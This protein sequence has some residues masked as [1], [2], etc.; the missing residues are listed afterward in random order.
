[1]GRKTK[2]EKGLL[3]KLLS[4]ALDGQVGDDLTTSGG[5]TVWTTIK[6]GK[7]ARYKEGPTKKFFNGKENE[8]IPGVK[9]TLEE[10]KTDDEKLSFLQKFGWLMKDED[11]RAYSSKFK[12]KKK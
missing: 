1:M 8:R 9:H 4:G 10:W 7:P 11:A 2:E 3:A 12:P 6:D 5:S